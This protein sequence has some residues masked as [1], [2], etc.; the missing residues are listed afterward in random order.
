MQ[1]HLL[2]PADFFKIVIQGNL[3]VCAADQGDAVSA[4]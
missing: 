4:N 3:F 2:T 1:E